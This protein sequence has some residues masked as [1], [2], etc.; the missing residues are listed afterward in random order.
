MYLIGF[1]HFQNPFL[2]GFR[3][4]HESPI[5]VPEVPTSI[6]SVPNVEIPAPCSI[7]VDLL[8]ASINTSPFKGLIPR[9]LE[10]VGPP[11]LFYSP[12]TAQF[13]ILTL[14]LNLIAA[15]EVFD[16]VRL[17]NEAFSA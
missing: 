1:I 16:M 4:D 8:E 12:S 6:A 5:T 10:P 11:S 9:P 3:A 2:D 13:I 17:V 14:L 7:R 15:T